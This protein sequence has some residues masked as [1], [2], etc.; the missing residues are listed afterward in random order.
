MVLVEDGKVTGNFLKEKSVRETAH[1]VVAGEVCKDTCASFRQG[2]YV[3]NFTSTSKVEAGK[4]LE[5]ILGFTS[6]NDHLREQLT[7]KYGNDEIIHTGKCVNACNNSAKCKN[8]IFLNSGSFVK[9]NLDE[10]GSCLLVTD[11]QVEKIINEFDMKEIGDGTTLG[12][13]DEIIVSIFTG[14]DFQLS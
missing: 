13:G 6:D 1:S 3:T 7:L 8:F 4:K 5:S 11:D 9:K 2:T 14:G 12:I 10:N